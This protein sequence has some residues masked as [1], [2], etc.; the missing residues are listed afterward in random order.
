MLTT[1]PTDDDRTLDDDGDNG[2]CD[3]EG[4]DCMTT[5]TTTLLLL[6]P[7]LLLLLLLLRLQLYGGYDSASR[8]I[9]F[10]YKPFSSS[11]RASRG[12]RGAAVGGRVAAPPSLQTLG[13]CKLNTASSTRMYVRQYVVIACRKCFGRTSRLAEC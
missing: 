4:D 3:D 7:L 1:A 12:V 5:T 6:L 2:G 10:I 8:R 13:R 11:A 9:P